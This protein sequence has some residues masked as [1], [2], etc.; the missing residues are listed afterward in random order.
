[1]RLYRRLTGTFALS[2]GRATSCNLRVRRTLERAVSSRS[3][4]WFALLTGRGGRPRSR[5]GTTGV[6]ALFGQVGKAISDFLGQPVVRLGL[7]VAV[8][9]VVTVWLATALWAF[10]DMRRRTANPIW[11]YA[12]A[13]AVVLASPVLFPLVVLVHIV[14][15]PSTSVGDRRIEALRD[16]ALRVEVDRPVCPGCGRSINEDWLICPVCRTTL[17]HLC[18]GC[19]HAAGTD[20]DACAWCGALFGPP[21]G[22]VARS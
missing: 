7:F 5:K 9:Y 12:S 15:R 16:A 14:V 20:W 17:G 1:M 10:G 8:G 13:A 22:A 2:V 6:D 11:P 3:P 21:A 4:P 19:G 18:E